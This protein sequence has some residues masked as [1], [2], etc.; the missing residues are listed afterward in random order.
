MP[1]EYTVLWTRAGSPLL[2]K[3]DTRGRVIALS[4]SM[5]VCLFSLFVCLF[6]GLFVDTKCTVVALQ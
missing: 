4:V 3:V 1:Y 2:T 5:F 6:V